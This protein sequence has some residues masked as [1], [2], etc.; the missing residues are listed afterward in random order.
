ML[1]QRVFSGFLRSA[2]LGMSLA[3]QPAPKGQ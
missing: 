2:R 3:Q 1:K